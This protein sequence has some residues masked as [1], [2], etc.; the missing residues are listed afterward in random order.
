ML[1]PCLVV[2][3][4]FTPRR[5]IEEMRALG[6]HRNAGQ[7]DPVTTAFQRDLNREQSRRPA[8]IVRG[9][10]DLGRA[11]FACVSPR[12]KVHIR[13]DQPALPQP[14]LRFFGVKR[15][16][17]IDSTKPC[18]DHVID[19]YEQIGPESIESLGA[20]RP[21]GRS[22]AEYQRTPHAFNIALARRIMRAASPL[23]FGLRMGPQ[24]T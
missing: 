8:P 24:L 17:D 19:G 5:S 16:D 4:G 7:Y 15:G 1:E 9:A 14:P 22:A 18:T 23:V 13:A 12:L 6:R 10:L 11:R 2:G 20:I 21:D 3:I